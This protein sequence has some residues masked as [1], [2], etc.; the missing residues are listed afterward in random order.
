MKITVQF[1]AMDTSIC[2]NNTT[3]A[4]SFNPFESGNSVSDIIYTI[5]NICLIVAIIFGN[6]LVLLSIARFKDLRS[7]TNAF[8][9]CLAV[10]DLFTGIAILYNFLVLTFN[11]KYETCM[12]FIFLLVLSLTS[13]LMFL[14]GMYDNLNSKSTQK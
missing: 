11:E 4:T 5:L 14:L 6:N 3:I 2:M 9:A 10:A 13:S 12:F 8:I 7:V 1:T